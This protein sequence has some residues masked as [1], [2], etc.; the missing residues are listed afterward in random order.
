MDVVSQ[1]VAELRGRLRV[2]SR[3]GEGMALRI[4]LPASLTSAHAAI[5]RVGEGWAAI[6]TSGVQRF[7]PV[8]DGAL[9]GDADELSMTLDGYPV[10][11]LWL[12][13]LFGQPLPRQ[14]QPARMAAVVIDDTGVQH[15]I[16]LREVE[17][18][19]EVIVRG[20]GPWVPGLPG[21]R[22]ATILGSGAV[23]PVIDL[24][25]LLAGAAVVAVAAAA[26]GD[27]ADIVVADDSLSVRRALAQ[28]LGDVGL[29]VRT[30]RDGLEALDLVKARRPALLVVDLEMPRMN[31][32]DLTA[33]LRT[34]P[35]T[36]DLP[37]LMVTSRTAETHQRLA[38]EAGV[39]EML[40][41][42]V[43]DDALLTAVMR[44]LESGRP[45][46]GAR[47]A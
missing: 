17:G 28:M 7:V 18:M 25:P 6:A 32:L 23:A 11:A 10:R 20:L 35:A 8:F 5:A 15:A 9:K 34:Q 4:E 27:A 40:P 46:S 30:P 41:K 37:V 36:A 45:V 39:D 16:L 38:F 26:D 2:D 24:A 43:S 21:V 13:S 42:P 44:L 12:E 1:R 22:G 33:Y 29:A 14:D 31:G 3:P 47:R 19:R